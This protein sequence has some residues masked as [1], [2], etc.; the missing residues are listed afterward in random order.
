MASTERDK[1]QTMAEAIDVIESIYE[2]MLAYAAQGRA[3]EQD[4]P[5]GIREALR[6]ANAA[7]DIIEATTPA[8]MGAPDGALSAAAAAMLAVLQQDAVRARAAFRFVAAQP[9]IGSQMIDNL[10]ASIHVRA[11][12]TDLFLIDE[13][14]E[15]GGQS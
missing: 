11:L 14:L 10:N 1:P 6:L 5:M 13:A 8:S 12:L 4:D 7:L 3:R 9:T 2:L 15:I